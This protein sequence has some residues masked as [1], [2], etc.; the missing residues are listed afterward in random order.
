MSML[1]K[2]L[3]QQ[4]I[5]AAKAVHA[6]LGGGLP[7]SFY[8]RAL[9]VELRN[10][11]MAPEAGKAVKLAYRGHPVGE[12]VIDF[13]VNNAVLCMLIETEEVSPE[14]YGKVRSL[15]KALDLEV[16][17]LLRFTGARLDIRR[18]EAVPRKQA[19]TA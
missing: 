1:H 18:V 13:C 8:R 15:L 12:L 2:D 5:N 19:Q 4:I 10:D 11:G 6:E 14:E 9:D 17:L 7:G 16:G 3:T